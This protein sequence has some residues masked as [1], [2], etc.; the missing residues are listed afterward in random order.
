MMMRRK[1]MISIMKNE[2]VFVLLLE[3]NPAQYTLL[4][5]Y[6]EREHYKVLL[7]NCIKTFHSLMKAEVPDIILLDLNLPDGDG[8]QLVRTI[9]L[10]HKIPLIIVSSRDRLTDRVTGLELGADDYICKPYHP[11]ELVIRIR[12]LLAYKREERR[13]SSQAIWINDFSFNEALCCFFDKGGK[14]IKLTAGEYTI[15][16]A[17][18]AGRGRILSR[19]QLL[20]VAFHRKA[21]PADR[22][23]DVLISRLRKKFPLQPEDP[24]IIETVKEFGYRVNTAALR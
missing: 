20:D 19:D 13:T 2:D 16:A 18:L 6:L 15:M 10:V 12:N 5:A 22:T 24:E 3:D 14:E 17:L 9:R 23:I 11:R 1:I 8:L 21:Y 7:A 4:A